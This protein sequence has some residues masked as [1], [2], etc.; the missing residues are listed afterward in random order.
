MYLISGKLLEETG[1]EVACV[2][3]P[4]RWKDLER[5]RHDYKGPRSSIGQQAEED[6]VAGGR[7]ERVS[8][9]A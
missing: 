4:F 9:L 8:E 3:V 2:V 1:V 5:L 6:I 7:R